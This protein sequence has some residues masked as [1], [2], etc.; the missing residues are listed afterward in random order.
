VRAPTL[1][2]F[3]ERYIAGRTDLKEGTRYLYRLAGRYLT[4]FFGAGTRIDHITRARA[5]DWRTAMKAREV[6]LL[7]ATEDGK[8]TI[9][10][11]RGALSEAT[12]CDNCKYAKSL[13]KQPSTTT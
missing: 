12:V 9:N 1:E 7:V 4:S 8:G 10:R 6:K 11:S 5:R 13:F 2:A 3:I